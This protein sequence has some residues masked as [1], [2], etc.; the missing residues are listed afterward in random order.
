M[1][2]PQAAP[3]LTECVG[4]PLGS[5]GLQHE[6]ERRVTAPFASPTLPQ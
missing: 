1:H 5:S 2:P 6:K 3:L 4:P